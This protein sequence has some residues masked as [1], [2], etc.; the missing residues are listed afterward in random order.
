MDHDQRM[1]SGPKNAMCR[2][3]QQGLAESCST[4]GRH[5]DWT[6]GRLRACDCRCVQRAD[7]LNQLA[8]LDPSVD[9]DLRGPMSQIIN[10]PT[11]VRLRRFDIK[12][13]FPGKLDI[14]V[15]YGHKFLRH[16]VRG[17]RRHNG[18]AQDEFTMEGSRELE[19]CRERGL[20]QGGAIQGNQQ[21]PAQQGPT[22][23]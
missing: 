13:G 11:E 23:R 19:R 16:R 6:D 5:D 20:G 21:P 8:D 1:I 17:A 3:A 12:T 18:L 10:H 4:V 15:V 14:D 7:L 2:A 22:R 9:H